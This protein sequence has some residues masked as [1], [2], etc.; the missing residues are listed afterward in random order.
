MKKLYIYFL[1]I[2]VTIISCTCIISVHAQ[3]PWIVNEDFSSN[4]NKW[5]LLENSSLTTRLSGDGYHI[6]VKDTSSHYIEHRFVLD[7]MHDFKIEADF[8]LISTSDMDLPYGLVF[9]SGE[10]SKQRYSFVI[11]GNG[12]YAVRQHALTGMNNIEGPKFAKNIIRT[13]TGN[14]NKLTVTKREGYWEFFINDVQVRMMQ[15][16][17]FAGDWIGFFVNANMHVVVS[18]F[19]VYD[20]TLAK[21]LPKYEKEPVV[22][23]KFHDNFFD[24]KNEWL[25]K[26]D[27]SANIL[28]IIIIMHLKIKPT[29][30]IPPGILQIC[31]NSPIA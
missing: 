11:T 17:P 15:P 22:S 3:S 16:Y 14:K 13:G 18:S 27:A 5:I 31:L 25:D 19:K 6:Q 1:R 2:I 28:S 8:Q 23:V 20:W 29:G 12:T 30:Y 21:G 4:I 24:N 10:S 7:Q 26:S 9:A